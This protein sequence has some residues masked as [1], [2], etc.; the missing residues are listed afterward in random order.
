[1][2]Y[3]TALP[4]NRPPPSKIRQLSNFFRS[5]PSRCEHRQG[6][7]KY[8]RPPRLWGRH[9]RVRATLFKKSTPRG[10]SQ[11]NPG[12]GHKGRPSLVTPS[13]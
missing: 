7:S 4:S 10:Y 9:P 5:D 2:P 3:P 1:M 8:R 13:S 11:S 6:A 12:G